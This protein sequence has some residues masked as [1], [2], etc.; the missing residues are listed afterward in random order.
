MDNQE[1][2]AFLSRGEISV[3]S[4][5]LHFI[6][7]ARTSR[8]VL[9]QHPV[10][11][12][13]YTAKDGSI[14]ISECAPIIGLSAESAEEVQAQLHGLCIVKDEREWRAQYQ[15]SSSSVRFAMEVLEQSLKAPHRF[16]PFNPKAGKVPIN[17]L[18]WMNDPET[19]LEE[20]LRKW[21]EGFRC[22]KFK[23]GAFDFEEEWAMLKVFRDQIGEEGIIR[24][25]AN[26]AWNASQA[27][28]NMERLASLNIH[29]IEQPI[30]K[31]NWDDMRKLCENAPIKIALDEELIG[32][33][34]LQMENLLDHIQPHFLVLKPSLHGGFRQC[35]RWIHLASERNIQWWATSALE[36][37]IGLNAIYRWVSQYQPSQYQGL[38]TGALYANNWES[39]LTI[40][41]GELF[42]DENKS[43]KHPW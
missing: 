14:E 42:A 13:E 17:G 12:L 20:G 9:Q 29:S 32:C 4:W 21:E 16:E 19:M 6:K 41:K 23:V 38:G 5:S 11:Y 18:V 26:G 33:D 25:D 40:E 2:L 7:S 37:N 34:V 43:W 3:R 28:K 27:L 31:G 22:I 1:H 35:D 39:P 8:N 15:K 36:S 30:A 10:H 24:L